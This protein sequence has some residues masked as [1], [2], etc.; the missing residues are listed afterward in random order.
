VQEWLQ[1]ARRAAWTHLPRTVRV[2]TSSD[3]W[4]A[5]VVDDFIEGDHGSRYGI[6]RH[7]RAQLA[8]AFATNLRHIPSGTSFV[9]HVALAKA[10]LSVQPEIPGVVVECGTW[11]GASAASLSLVCRRIGRRL[12]VCDSFE[13]LPDDGLRVHVAPHFGTWGYY[14]KGMFSGSLEEVQA[15]VRE[16]GAIEVCTFLP[17]YFSE[18]LRALSDPVVFA[19]LDVDLVHSTQ[20]CLRFIWPLLVEG[21][22]IYTDDAGDLDVV[23]VFFDERWWRETFRC[24]PPGY[25]GSGCGLPL[26]ATYSSLGYARK[27]ADFD[28]DRWVKA[29]HLYHPKTGNP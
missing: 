20:D 28:S 5:Y 21:G 3:P 12:T 7:D 8:S 10:V 18:S 26:G 9:H 19:F 24:D 27:F 14:K 1:G 23:R 29:P 17:G 16:F 4:A 15:N 22:A 2:R 11:K 6:T 25:V 13:G